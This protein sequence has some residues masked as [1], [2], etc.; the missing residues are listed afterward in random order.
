MMITIAVVRSRRV[1]QSCRRLARLYSECPVRFIKTI[2]VKIHEFI[3]IA[4][5]F[6]S[7]R[8]RLPSRF[9]RRRARAEHL[10]RHRRPGYRC[11]GQPV[12]GANVTI[13]HIESGTV[14]TAITDANGR[15]SARGLRVGGPYTI[16]IIKDGMTETREQRVPAA[17]RN[18]NRRCRAERRD[19]SWK[20]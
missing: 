3:S 5:G 4:F 13:T 17:G 16:T 19:K 1:I 12:A 2:Q 20:P 7:S 18:H 11:D 15:Y 10:L 9:R 14:S 8:L 6:P